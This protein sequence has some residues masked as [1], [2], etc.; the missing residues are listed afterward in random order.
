MMLDKLNTLI[1]KKQKNKLYI[2]LALIFFASV[3]EMIGVGS[4]PVFLGFLLD[5][6][7]IFDFLTNYKFFDNFEKDII[8]FYSG[9]ILI[10]FF[11][12]KNLFIFF[13]NFYQSRLAKDLNVENSTKLFNLY[14]DLPFSKFLEKNPSIITRNISVDVI[15]ANQYVVSLI[16]FIR[17]ILIIIVMLILLVVVDFFSSSLIFTSLI[18]FS[19]IFYFLFRNKITNLSVLSQKLR[20]QQ[21][22]LV[23]QIF[24][25]I[26]EI[27]IY[28]KEK[29]LKELF[30]FSTDGVEKINF[31]VQVINKIPR[32]LIEVIFIFIVL[33]TIFFY[34]SSN[35]NIDS[36]VPTLTFLGVAL[37]RMIP[38]FSTIIILL[39]AL[40]KTLVSFNLVVNDLKIY[41]TI[42]QDDILEKNNLKNQNNFQKFSRCNSIIFKNINFNYEG[43][44]DLIFKD[45]NLDIDLKKTNAI[46]GKTGSGKTTLINLILGL[47]SPSEGEIF[48]DEKPLKN[49]LKNWHENISIVPQDIY[50]LDDT[51]LNNITFGVNDKIIDKHHLEKVI[52]KSKIDKLINNLPEKENT[53]VGNQ[54]V[55]LSGGQKQRVAIARA[56]YRKR[57][58]II[59]DE[60]TS[61][62]DIET[63]KELLNDLL[64]LKKELSLIVITHR[65]KTIEEFDNIYFVKDKNVKTINKNLINKS[66]ESLLI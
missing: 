30:K 42:R 36:L 45:L 53:I 6:D 15:N 29:K 5:S 61:S 50:L 8:L 48:I 58:V 64:K 40:R 11:I 14:L 41:S 20:A 24:G 65:L 27:K 3:L 52:K 51:I 66:L 44:K 19:L 49:S 28:S 1:S 38:S 23:N 33:I 39:N 32:L 34:I 47:L 62:L 31:F 26:K 59:F 54:G 63:E 37:I 10:L 9:I 13:V 35:N 55:K 43:N 22:K 46:V 25:S 57:G 2:L 60:A 16:N 12:F 21:I 56:L 4:I 18:T 17:E 7:K